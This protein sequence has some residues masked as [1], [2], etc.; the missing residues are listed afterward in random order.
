MIGNYASI[1]KSTDI[2]DSFIFLLNP[3]INIVTII[4]FNKENFII[5]SS[6]KPQKSNADFIS[7]EMICLHVNNL[8][9]MM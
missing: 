5:K 6:T 9:Y 4:L 3:Y 7:I 1:L 2:Y 8:V